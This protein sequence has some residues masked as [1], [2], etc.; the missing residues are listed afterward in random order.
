MIVK[1]FILFWIVYYRIKP[2]N[3][4]SSILFDRENTIENDHRKC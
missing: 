4:S 3:K 1:N 2:L